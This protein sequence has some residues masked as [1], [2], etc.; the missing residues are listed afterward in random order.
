MIKTD[1]NI[2]RD[3][4]TIHGCEYRPNTAN[5]QPAL[6]ISE[7]YP[8]PMTDLTLLANF[9]A[10]LGFTV[11]LFD[12]VGGS[13]SSTSTGQTTDMTLLTEV[14]DL[15]AVIN[16]VSQRSYIDSE[17]INL[18]GCSQGGLISALVAAAHPKTVNKL[19]LLSPA[20]SIPTTVSQMTVGKHL[21]LDELPETFEL[22]NITLSK[23]YITDALSL[24]HHVWDKLATFKK[25]VLICHGDADEVINVSY[26][27]QAV[28]Q[29]PNAKLVELPNS[30]HLFQNI[31]FNRVVEESAT[32]LFAVP[33]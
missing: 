31:G 29:F 7:G 4:F 25:P 8:E 18:L 10:N 14:A 30:N 2:S 5:R 3:Q 19:I 16:N 23:K 33:A 22:E 6:I 17:Q 27:K 26:A 32:F 24:H 11:Y 15:E 20:F 13:P 9:F 28:N 1:F 21:T 12:F